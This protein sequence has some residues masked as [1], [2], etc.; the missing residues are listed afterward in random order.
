MISIRCVIGVIKCEPVIAR[1]RGG[2]GGTMLETGIKGEAAEIVTE[3]NTARAMG[4]GMLEVYATPAMIALI[5][6]AACE[7]V[8]P[9]LET[10][11][12]TVGTLLQVK[13]LSAS[14]VG[15]KI[16]A[17]TTLTE[18]DRKRL[19]FAVE[20]YDET[21]KIGEGIHERFIIDNEAFF[22][23]ANQKWEAEG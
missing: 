11:K 18:I 12:G 13:H 2:M 14:P 17:R 1:L 5:E 20:A 8:A 10:G 4:S 15:M 16:T 6:K 23:K 21:G 3:R 19:T 7:S 9:E 22:N